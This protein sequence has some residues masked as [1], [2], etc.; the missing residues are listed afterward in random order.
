VLPKT[1]IPSVGWI[2]KFLDTEE[3]LV[4][5]MEYHKNRQ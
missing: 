4:C 3:N 1:E 2:I 5:A